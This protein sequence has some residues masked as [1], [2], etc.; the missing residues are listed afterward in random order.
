M[1]TAVG[2]YNGGND[3]TAEGGT[4]LVEQVVIY[5]IIFLVFVISD[6]KAGTVGSQ[7]AVQS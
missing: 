2:V 1:R 4:D 3:V 6:F 7:A 5:F